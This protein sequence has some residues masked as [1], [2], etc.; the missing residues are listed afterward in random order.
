[1]PAQM[2]PAR[3]AALVKG[4]SKAKIK[5]LV[6]LSACTG[7]EVCIAVCPVPTCIEKFGDDPTNWGVYVN[8]DICIGCMLCVKDCPWDTIR[9]VPTDSIKEHK[10]SLD[11]QLTHDHAIFSNPQVVEEELRTFE[12]K[13][14]FNNPQV[15]QLFQKQ[16]PQVPN[17]MGPK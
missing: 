10:T 17:L 12:G 2:N 3:R 8:Y 4:A 13:P 1:M 15:Q 14:P 9:M 7:C 16:N 5:A 11:S 6:N